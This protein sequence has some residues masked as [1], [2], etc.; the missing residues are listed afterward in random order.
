MRIL[1][2][3]CPF[4][5]RL[6]H[7]LIF[8]LLLFFH[9]RQRITKKHTSYQRP[10]SAP[11]PACAAAASASL[12]AGSLA[13]W[14]RW[15]SHSAIGKDSTFWVCWRCRWRGRAFADGE[16]G[17][18]CDEEAIVCGAGCFAICATCDPLGGRLINILVAKES[19]L[20]WSMFVGRRGRLRKR[21]ED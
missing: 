6:P 19:C 11:R 2:A 3:K 17:V 14:L 1:L 18:W 9:R 21:I 10:A 12:A 13:H 20:C 7:P 4:L 16:A 8:S 5:I 15:R